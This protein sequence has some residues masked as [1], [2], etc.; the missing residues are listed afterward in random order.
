MPTLDVTSV[1]SS[2]AFADSFQVLRQTQT[3]GCDGIAHNDATRLY[4]SGVVAPS[5]TM[6]LV[7]NAAGEMVVGDIDIITTFILIDGKSG[8]DADLVVYKGNSYTVIDVASY[9]QFGAGFVRAAC[10]LSTVQSS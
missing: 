6:R 3:V 10:R 5:S 9:A 1:L 7:R 4:A 8:Y 2:P